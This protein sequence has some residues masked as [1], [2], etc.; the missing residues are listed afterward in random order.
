MAQYLDR[1][2]GAARP[3]VAAIQT[4]VTPTEVIDHQRT[5]I[6]ME[7]SNHEIVELALK[8]NLY[9]KPGHTKILAQQIR[10]PVFFLFE[11]LTQTDF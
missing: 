5:G 8:P 7:S 2:V 10:W 6:N 1:T 9:S 11:D 4:P 3:H